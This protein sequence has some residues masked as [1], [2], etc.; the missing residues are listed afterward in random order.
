LASFSIFGFTEK[1]PRTSASVVDHTAT[2]NI[3]PRLAHVS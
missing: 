3:M 1:K 2:P